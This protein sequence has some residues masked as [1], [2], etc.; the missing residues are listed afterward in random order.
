MS[1]LGLEIVLDTLSLRRRGI[2]GR[3][4]GRLAR[5][6]GMAWV[7][8]S[9]RL[10]GKTGSSSQRQ[11]RCVSPS[12]ATRR[13]TG[14]GGGT[15][16]RAG[17]ASHARCLAGCKPLR[18]HLWR[19]PSLLRAR[20]LR[21]QLTPRWLWR[22]RTRALTLC[23]SKLHLPPQ[24]PPPPPPLPLP[25]TPTR[26]PPEP[27]PRARMWRREVESPATLRERDRAGCLSAQLRRHVSSKLCVSGQSARATSLAAFSCA[28]SSKLPRPSSRAASFE[29]S[30]TPQ[31]P[32]LR[33]RAGEQVQASSSCTICVRSCARRGRCSSASWPLQSSRRPASASCATSSRR[34]KRALRR[35]RQTRQLC[36]RSS[37]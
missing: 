17:K 10:P 22:W 26:P 37:I 13:L 29:G 4:C 14:A 35:S 3:A 31:W 30:A 1:S 5:G 12:C 24:A 23:S 16:W 11:G 7:K 9:S 6:W 33:P 28:R 19:P 8:V 15:R 20:R 34:A 36:A 18:S 2:A 32:T 25:P 27:P 21:V